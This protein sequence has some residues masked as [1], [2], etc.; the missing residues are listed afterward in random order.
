MTTFKEYLAE[1]TRNE[2]AELVKSTFKGLDKDQTL[3]Y[4]AQHCK[5]ALAEF[6]AGRVIY[7]GV[8]TGEE[9][10]FINPSSIDRKSANTYNLYNIILSESSKWAKYPRRDKSAICT[11]DMWKASRYSYN[12]MPHVVLPVDGFQLGVCPHDDIFKSFD[13]MLKSLLGVSQPSLRFF[14]GFIV[15]TLVMSGV[16]SAQTD[17]QKILD[18]GRAFDDVF[19]DVSKTKHLFSEFDRRYVNNNKDIAKLL[20]TVA[21]TGPGAQ[22][23]PILVMRLLQNYKGDLWKTC[24]QILDPSANGFQLLKNQFPDTRMSTEV[25]TDSDCIMIEG[26]DKNLEALMLLK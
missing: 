16:V 24:E 2:R 5:K 11:T 1:M 4:V 7:R 9:Y 6:K 15:A 22:Q 13:D 14:N 10:G 20:A 21:L 3:E 25:W 17:F 12:G 26:T 23:A 18:D 19:H 8:K